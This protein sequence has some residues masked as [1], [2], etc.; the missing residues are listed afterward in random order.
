M[1]RKTSGGGDGTR[2]PILVEAKPNARWSLDLSRQFAIARASRTQQEELTN[3]I[4]GEF[5]DRELGRRMHREADATVKSRRSK[6][7]L[8][9][10]TIPALPDGV[11]HSLNWPLFSGSCQT[12]GSKQSESNCSTKPT[13]SEKIGVSYLLTGAG[14]GSKA[15]L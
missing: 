1:R 9:K 6:A 11:R 4:L 14:R 12:L 13:R 15:T 3:L 7:R 8:L 5:S 10:V 2:A